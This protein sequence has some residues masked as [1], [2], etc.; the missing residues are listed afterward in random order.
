MC[1]GNL[2]SRWLGWKNED[3]T[4]APPSDTIRGSGRSLVVFLED[5]EHISAKFFLRQNLTAGS[6]SANLTESCTR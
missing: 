4:N 6:S 1:A 3:S 5:A 2:E